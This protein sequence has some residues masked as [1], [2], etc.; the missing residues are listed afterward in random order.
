MK[1]LILN[2]YFNRSNF[3]YLLLPFSEQG[4]LLN[5]YSLLSFLFSFSKQVNSI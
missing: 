2:K 5:P 1:Y 3:Y 4:D